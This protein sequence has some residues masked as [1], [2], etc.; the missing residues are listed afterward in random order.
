M[1]QFDPK[2]YV[3]FVNLRK[4]QTG[5]ST[6]ATLDGEVKMIVNKYDKAGNPV[7]RNFNFSKTQR[8]MRIP[9]NQKDVAGNSVVEFLRNHP[10]CKDSPNSRGITTFAEINTD[11]EASEALEA[12]KK[13]L[14]AENLAINL[15]AEELAEIAAVFGI[16]NASPVVTQWRIQEIA[17][18]DPEAFIDV[19]EDPARSARALIRKALKHDIL[20]RR[21]AI[22]MWEDEQI[23]PDEE[24]AV[25]TI[26]KDERLKGALQEAVVRY[27]GGPAKPKAKASAKEKV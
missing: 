2:N 8:T 4:G 11:K 26:M 14:K 19:A 21:G 27:E 13:K 17:Q 6:Y 16:F 23:G 22:V 12:K 9:I 3:Y 20:K 7:P 1:S 15:E 24:S 25:T 10:E 5:F 18:N